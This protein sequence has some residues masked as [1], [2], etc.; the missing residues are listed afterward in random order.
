[1]KKISIKKKQIQIKLRLAIIT[2]L[3]IIVIISAYTT[4]AA[5]Q[6]PIT[7]EKNI[8]TCE[9]SHNGKFDYTVHLKNN[10]IYDNTSIL[11]PGQEIIFRK[12]TES[13]KAS[14]TYQFHC[15]QTADIQGYCT[16][17][18]QLN[19]DLWSKEYT[20]I[21]KTSFSSNGNIASFNASFSIN[22]TRFESIVN[23][24]DAETGVSAGDLKLIINCD[25]I[26]SAETSTGNIYEPFSSSLSVPLRESIIQ[27]NGDLLQ[28]KSGVLEETEEVFEPGVIEQRNIWGLA[29]IILFIILIVFLA[30]TRS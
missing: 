16:V 12:L 11:Q 5:F 21:P 23:Q 20:L 8:I 24:I 4:F 15:D 26:L 2:I 9:Y 25:V 6:Q 7:T 28:Y 14:F 29:S 18:A 3:S 30:F 22:Y 10:T 19:T 1:M 17:L 13:I 27:I